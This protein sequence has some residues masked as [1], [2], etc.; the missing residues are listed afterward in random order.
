[1]AG[2]EGGT[3]WLHSLPKGEN[4]SSQPL[5]REIKEAAPFRLQGLPPTL[6][7]PAGVGTK[8]HVFGRA[9]AKGRK[10]APSWRDVDC[11]P[12]VRSLRFSL[13]LPLPPSPWA[14]NQRDRHWEL[15]HRKLPDGGNPLCSHQVP[16]QTALNLCRDCPA[17]QR[18]GKWC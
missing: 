2:V 4:C 16:V 17:P 10:Q 9:L 5:G 13:S 1:M 12:C 18:L 3:G 15:G 6:Y 11:E 14:I 8:G 7:P